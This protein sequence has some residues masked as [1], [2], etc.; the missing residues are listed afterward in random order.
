MINMA[1]ITVRLDPILKDKIS[2]A[3]ISEGSN[4]SEFVR[5]ACMERLERM[6]AEIKSARFLKDFIVDLL[7]KGFDPIALRQMGYNRDLIKAS[8]D[9]VKNLAE[10]SE[11]LQ[12]YLSFRERAKLQAELCQ[13]CKIIEYLIALLEME[14]L[15]RKALEYY[16]FLCTKTL[17]RPPILE[18]LSRGNELA[19]YLKLTIFLIKFLK[20]MESKFFDEKVTPDDFIMK[21]LGVPFTVFWNSLENPENIIRNLIKHERKVQ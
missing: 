3:A 2:K 13:H 12:R 18:I 1:S 15:K 11:E 10:M 14:M 19:Q 4:V 6:E 21:E 17:G 7:C 20:E 9:E 16:L 5:K 8:F